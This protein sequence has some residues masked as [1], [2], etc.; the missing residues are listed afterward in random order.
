[1]ISYCMTDTA[2]SHGENDRG[3]AAMTSFPVPSYHWGMKNSSV[4][5]GR[6][7][8]INI[9]GRSTELSEM[10]SFLPTGQGMRF[11]LPVKVP[12]GSSASSK[13]SR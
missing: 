7:Y 11:A 9:R 2:T 6:S 12:C 1:M 10:P 8:S 13:I 4:G 3:K 5:I